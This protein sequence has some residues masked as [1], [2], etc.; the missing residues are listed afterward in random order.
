MKTAIVTCVSENWLAPACVTLLSVAR[1]SASA[2]TDYYIIAE[3]LSSQS[4]SEVAEF[5][6]RHQIKINLLT[7]A[8]AGFSSLDAHR[9]SSATFL[10]LCLPE[11]IP[12]TYDRLL[13]LDSDVLALA[14]ISTLLTID[15]G[16]MPLGAVPEIKLAQGRG[17]LTDRHRHQIGLSKTQDYFNAGVLIF[18]WQK[19][20]ANRLL[21]KS[22]DMLLSGKHFEFLDQDVLNLV[23]QDQWKALPLKWN[24]E[25]SAA[26][27][28]GVPPALRHFNHA[29]KPWDWPNIMA[30]APHH[31]YYRQAL[32]GLALSQFMNKPKRGSALLASIEY[33]LRKAS[34][35]QRRFLRKRYAHL[36]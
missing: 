11:I 20:C 26:C 28:L 16:G 24:V 34:L 14:E 10:R 7:H 23:F 13:Y 29:A 3:E 30:Y 8:P 9:Y 22:R 19:T 32:D 18:D 15:L 31:E 25:Q 35:H 21:E 12:Q 36:L 33:H 27:Y 17:I 4:R 6:T 2:I 5:E 1:N